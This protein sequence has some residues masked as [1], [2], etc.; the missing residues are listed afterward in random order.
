MYKRYKN[1]ITTNSD[2]S[3]N[4][5]NNSE[6]NAAVNKEKKEETEFPINKNKKKEENEEK[7]VIKKIIFCELCEKRLDSKQ[8]YIL[9]MSSKSHK[10]KTK[11]LLRK[12]LKECGSVRKVL[13]K[14][15]LIAPYRR[16]KV[17]N[18]RYLLYGFAL[19]RYINK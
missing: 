12:E 11:E 14:E 2:L 4:E 6:T 8:D 15:K 19:N 10:H 3:D 1:Y 18:V 9:H 16:W 5:D 13:I 17:N 7:V